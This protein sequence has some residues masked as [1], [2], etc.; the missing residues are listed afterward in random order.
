MSK[1]L[2]LAWVFASGLAAALL[3][4]TLNFFVTETQEFQILLPNWLPASAIAIFG[5]LGCP[6]VA[7]VLPGLVLR[8]LKPAIP[9]T[10]W[11]LGWIAYVGLLFLVVVNFRSVDF[12]RDLEGVSPRFN[13]AWHNV[14]ATYFILPFLF[15]AP[16]MFALAMWRKSP[17]MGLNFGLAMATGSLVQAL[18][19]ITFENLR[20]VPDHRMNGG[21]ESLSWNH[22]PYLFGLFLTACCGAGAS[23]LVLARGTQAKT[24]LKSM[25]LAVTLLIGVSV[26]GPVVL[27]YVSAP[28]GLAADFSRLQKFMTTPPL[29]DESVGKPIVSFDATVEHDTARY[30]NAPAFAF[31]Q[32]EPDSR[33]FMTFDRERN[34]FVV[35]STT[36]QV[37]S[38]VAGPFDEKEN[39]SF[40]W[41]RD[42]KSFV[43]RTGIKENDDPFG[44]KGRM[45]SRIRVF[46]VPDYTLVN[47]RLAPMQ[48]PVSRMFDPPVEL[49]H[50]RAF[51]M[52]CEPYE[53]SRQGRA[54][55]IRVPVDGKGAIERIDFDALALP[56]RHSEMLVTKHGTYGVREDSKEGRGTSI[57]LSDLDGKSVTRK[58]AR[59]EEKSVAGGM[60]FQGMVQ[61]PEE[62][63][64]RFCGSSKD[65]SNPP[66]VRNDTDTRRWCRA[67]FYDAK[68][69][70]FLR[71]EDEM[72]DG[73]ITTFLPKSVMDVGALT[74]ESEWQS[75]SKTGEIRV[76]DRKSKTVLQKITTLNQSIAGVSPDLSRI[77]TIAFDQGRLRIYRIDAAAR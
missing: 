9:L 52:R 60:T 25:V 38:H 24:S 34:L 19:R 22:A 55:F 33:A 16:A 48:C 20:L 41:T 63:V 62:L 54:E 29:V 45:T 70:D 14:I 27:I 65:V 71:Y 66:I 17:R 39:L 72:V 12:V 7:M 47:D 31:V 40:A 35:N 18:S 76:L 10:I 61:R 42:G 75:S 44:L 15:W 68:T 49:Q 37:E 36:G 30:P 32:F 43:L 74:I 51:V 56:G 26:L 23:G 4:L 53:A 5:F 67:V 59:L 21:I 69:M 64:A 57:W 6:I 50:Q 13:G 73:Q 1:R 11:A 3:S 77:V 46:S 58:L 8:K 28:R 2:Y